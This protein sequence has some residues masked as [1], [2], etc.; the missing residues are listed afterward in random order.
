MLVFSMCVEI[1]HTA[2]VIWDQR[3]VVKVCFPSCAQSSLI[4]MGRHGA[5]KAKRSHPMMMPMPF[6]MPQQ[7]A[8]DEESSSND[9]STKHANEKTPAEPS[10]GIQRVPIPRN[11][12]TVKALGTCEIGRLIQLVKPSCDGAW[13]AQLSLMG[14][15][16]MLFICSRV[17]PISN[18]RD[19]RSSALIDLVK[20]F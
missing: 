17:L 3:F 19:L 20:Y 5:K 4:A 12:T 15:L 10:Y 6:M 1:N 8:Q 7:V 18:M 2:T 14:R 11:S 9:E 13:S 16:A